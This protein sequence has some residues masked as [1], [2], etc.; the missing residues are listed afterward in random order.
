MLPI[1]GVP[2]PMRKGLRPYRDVFRRAKGFADVSRSVTGVSVSPN[3][4]LQGIDAE[5]VGEAHKPT[6]RTRHEAVCE[7][8]RRSRQPLAAASA[9][10]EGP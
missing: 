9:E 2:D 8:G 10:S 5:Q 1:G 4:T 7:A 6:R 3:T